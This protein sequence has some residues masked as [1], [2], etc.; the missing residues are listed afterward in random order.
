MRP[1]QASTP[2]NIF[3]KNQSAAT[4]CIGYVELTLPDFAHIVSEFPE[5]AEL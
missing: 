4:L 1:S 2:M 5:V 3:A